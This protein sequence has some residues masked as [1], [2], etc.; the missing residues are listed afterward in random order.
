[1][2]LSNPSSGNSTE[3]ERKNPVIMEGIDIESHAVAESHLVNTTVKNI[4]WKGV[5]VT[6]KDRETKEPKNIVDNVEGIV[7]AGKSCSC[8]CI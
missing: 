1:M 4:S 5:T 7:E 8:L 6:V 3:V 2:G